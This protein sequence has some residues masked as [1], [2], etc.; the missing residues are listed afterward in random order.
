MNSSPSQNM[1]KPLLPPR[2]TPSLIL[3]NR[4][5]L[6]RRTGRT[7]NDSASVVFYYE[8]EQRTKE[9][10]SRRTTYRPKDSKDLRNVS[11]RICFVNVLGL[12]WRLSSDIKLRHEERASQQRLPL[13]ANER[14]AHPATPDTPIVIPTYR[15]TPFHGTVPCHSP[16]SP[17]R[18]Q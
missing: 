4:E 1:S 16:G 5:R 12:F 17:C 14:V 15:L 13:S 18:Q 10:A 11:T 9:V 7:N 8:Q 6:P 3:P 2:L